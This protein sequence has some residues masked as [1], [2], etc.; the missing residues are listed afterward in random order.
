MGTIKRVGIQL[1]AAEKKEAQ[2]EKAEHQALRSV[3]RN[4]E[5]EAKAL[6]KIQKHVASDAVK[7]GSDQ[8][9]REALQKGAKSAQAA[10]KKTT[11]AILQVRTA[12]EAR[13]AE[14]EA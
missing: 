13:K 7:V 9:A 2:T 14:K 8:G 4:Q 10:A 6:K 5:K 12:R 11:S 3:E 1:K